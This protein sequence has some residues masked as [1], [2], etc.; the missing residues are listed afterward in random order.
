M[1][2]AS[3]KGRA[4]Y[5]SAREHAQ[6]KLIYSG[7]LEK[8]SSGVLSQWHKRFFQ[9]SGKHLRYF[10]APPDPNDPEPPV[11]AAV[12]LSQLVQIRAGAPGDLKAGVKLFFSETSM[13]HVRWSVASH[14]VQWMHAFS[15]VNVLGPLI[16][17]FPEPGLGHKH[18]IEVLPEVFGTKF[19]RAKLAEA[20]LNA[21]PAGQGS[22]V[23]ALPGYQARADISD[24]LKFVAAAVSLREIVGAAEY[25]RCVNRRGVRVN[26]QSRAPEVSLSV[27]RLSECAVR[28]VWGSVSARGCCCCSHALRLWRH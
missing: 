21:A 4:L 9:I 5:G 11:K 20:T 28:A 7:W 3:T 2:R 19:E 1:S 17:R 8:K 12:D 23:A 15:A 6:D 10:S 25:D 13:L 24:A 22:A 27:E 16:A 18:W 26:V 14:G